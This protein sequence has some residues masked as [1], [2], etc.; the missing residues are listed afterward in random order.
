[1][2]KVRA[3]LSKFVN[4]YHPETLSDLLQILQGSI[5]DITNTI[6]AAVLKFGIN[7][8]KFLGVVI[9]R[10]ALTFPPIKMYVLV[11]ILKL[12]LR[13]PAESDK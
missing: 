11:G 8:A 9:F 10:R 12:V 2:G 1:M 4:F 13:G 3:T 7:T 5:L 6:A